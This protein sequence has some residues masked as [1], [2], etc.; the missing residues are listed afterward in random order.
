[1][2]CLLS[3][4][5]QVS[6]VWTVD[7]CNIVLSIF[8]C[9]FEA[10]SFSPFFLTILI[11]F[12]FSPLLRIGLSRALTHFKKM[13]FH[14][15][16]SRNGL[17]VLQRHITCGRLREWS[18]LCKQMKFWLVIHLKIIPGSIYDDS[19]KTYLYVLQRFFFRNLARDRY[20]I[21]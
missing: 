6:I 5:L 10:L 20:T 21:F 12:Y 11:L 15:P 19:N 13:F 17:T 16:L 18:K 7:Q 4:Y 3:R 14:L 9:L 2:S 1:M 8:A